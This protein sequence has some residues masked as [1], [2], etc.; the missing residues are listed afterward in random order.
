MSN[1]KIS[2]EQELRELRVEVQTMGMIPPVDHLPCWDH[3]SQWWKNGTGWSGEE[4]C[5]IMFVGFLMEVS[6]HILQ[7]N[8]EINAVRADIQ[9]SFDVLYKGVASHRKPN[10]F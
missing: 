7:T 3:F 9:Q 10:D 2:D 1:L 4:C 6:E 5:I 8:A